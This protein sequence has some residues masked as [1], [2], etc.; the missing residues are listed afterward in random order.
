[1]LTRVRAGL[2]HLSVSALVALIAVGIVFLLWYP[3]PLHRAVGV[4]EIFFIVLG[5]DVVIG[6]LLTTVV[7]KQG[8]KSLR[9]DL[10]TIAALQLAAFAY[11]MWTVAEGRPAWLV[12]SADR[13]DLV[14][15]YEVDQRKLS[16]AKPEY[17]TVSWSGPRWVFAHR[18]DSAEQRQTILFEA[19]MAGV[20]MPHRPEL[21]QPLEAGAAGIRERALPLDELARY[22]TQADVD[23]VRRRWPEANAYLPMMARVRPMTV[24]IEK[25][26]ARVIAVVDL[27][28]WQ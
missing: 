13:F 28:P 6:P 11:G 12:F 22:N 25:S 16:E 20:D 15:A 8:K 5:V 26:S 24:L 14:Q 4:T 21:Y 10:A 23:T 3:Q 9:F 18:P 17:R 27:T 7:Y 2:I 1:M 19:M